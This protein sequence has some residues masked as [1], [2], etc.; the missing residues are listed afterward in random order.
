MLDVELINIC[1]HL[2]NTLDTRVAEFEKFMAVDAYQVIV[3]P[4][5]EGP[6]ILGLV[7]PELMAHDEVAFDEKLKGI[8]D[9]RAADAMSRLLEAEIEFIGIDVV[10]DSVNFLKHGKSFRSLPL[11]SLLKKGAE[12]GA[13]L[14]QLF[15]RDCHVELLLTFGCGNAFSRRAVPAGAAGRVR[16]STC[17]AIIV[18]NG[19]SSTAALNA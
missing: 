3:L 8:I 16:I 19:T 7:L 14:F 15:S 13:H 2:L 18:E 5:T 1:D 10:I 11:T 6:F 12:D 4:V 17:S 9:R